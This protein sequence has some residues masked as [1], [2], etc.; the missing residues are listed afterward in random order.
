[1]LASNQLAALRLLKMAAAF[2]LASTLLAAV[3]PIA[4]SADPPPSHLNPDKVTCQSLRETLSRPRWLSAPMSRLVVNPNYTVTGSEAPTQVPTEISSNTAQIAYYV[5]ERPVQLPG[6]LSWAPVRPADSPDNIS[7]GQ[8]LDFAKAAW[9]AQR[10]IGD[11]RDGELRVTPTVD[12]GSLNWQVTADLDKAPCL[13]I[14]VASCTGHWAIKVNDGGVDIPLIMDSQDTGARLRNIAA[15]TGWHGTKAFTIKVFAVGGPKKSVAISRLQFVKMPVHKPLRPAILMWQP[16]Q[17][18]SIITTSDGAL[19]VK[20]TTAL[21]DANTLA[22]RLHI[23]KANGGSLRIMGRFSDG[24]PAWDSAHRLLLLA[25][26]N[27]HVTLAFSRQVRW[28]GVRPSVIDWAVHSGAPDAQSG[29]WAVELDSV[30]PS[31][32]FVVAAHFSPT[33]QVQ[34]GAPDASPKNFASELAHQEALWNRRLASVPHPLDFTP[35]ALP[36]EGVTAAQV[37]QTYYRAW[38]FL[39]ADSLPPMPENKFAYPQ[40]AAG[41]PSLWSEG[42]PGSRASAQWESFL[43]M[44][45]LALAEPKV[46][47]ESY[48]GQLS[49]LGPDGSLN[50]EG[51]PSCHV[52]TA[53][54]LYQ[55]TGDKA[56]L[57][58]LYPEIRKFL[59]WKIANPRWILNGATPSDSKDNE[60][61]AH[62]LTDIDYAAKVAAVLDKPDEV[63]FWHAQ[64]ATL[65]SNFHKWFWQPPSGPMYRI[66]RAST[67]QRSGADNAWN[68]EALILPPDILTAPERKNLLASYKSKVNVSLPF[69]IA[70]LTKFPD[71]ESA[72]KGLIQDGRIDEAA[73]LADAGMRDVTRAGEFSEVYDQSNPPMPAGVRPSIFGMRHAIDDVLWHNGIVFDE[74]LPV[75]VGMPHAVGVTNLPVRGV[76]ISVR[77][78]AH[79]EVTLEGPGL[80][81]LRLPNGFAAARLPS[82]GLRWTGKIALGQQVPL[83][84]NR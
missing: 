7:L 84:R 56:R 68:L 57:S 29:V 16:D 17:I 35:R 73:A 30:K 18:N 42:A 43:A 47:W 70:G 74:G 61:V 10:A 72:W 78:G 20:T 76:P 38:V 75:L 28:L 33:S 49:L 46:A 8:T 2:A 60:F 54:Q 9:T 69:L 13:L 65:A 31:E 44:Q 79:S 50:G 6:F 55:A 58:R 15:A 23:V 66:Y 5:G 11:A 63:K 19:S 80:R 48:E 12:Y 4:C 27:F 67:G 3:T 81:G 64:R 40:L 36:A 1:M 53:W 37:R 77:Y 83:E 32:D 34:A 14:Q 51:L 82:G 71:F 24:P 45:A 21:L 39:F 62:A 22:E 25:G 26:A 59:L 41:K 52:Q